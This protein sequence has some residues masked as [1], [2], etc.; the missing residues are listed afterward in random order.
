MKKIA[1]GTALLAVICSVH[2]GY[3]QASP[4]TPTTSPATIA[5]R[6]EVYHVA[7]MHAAA[8]KVNALEDWGKKAGA[9]SPISGHAVFLR[10]EAGS[11]WDYVGIQHLGAKGAVDANGN[12]QGAALRPL[13][14]WH[15]D[16]FVNGPAWADFAKAMGLDES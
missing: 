3:G 2:L 8:G 5:R 10:H 16:T 4:A 14:D 7:F 15:D 1:L 6:P 13:M 11:P 12:P 9:N